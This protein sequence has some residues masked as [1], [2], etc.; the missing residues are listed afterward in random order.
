MRG[1]R[2][3]I[4]ALAIASAIAGL[5]YLVQ[6]HDSSPEHSSN[7][8]AANGASAVRLFAEAMGHPT[9]QVEGSFDMPANESLLFVFTPTS[10]YTSDDA[11]EVAA[12]VRNGGVLVYASEEGDPELD[13]ALSVSRANGIVTSDV[14]TALPILDSVSKAAGGDT[15]VPLLPSAS[16]VAV[17][18][19][20]DGYALGYIEHLGFGEVVVLADP[21]VICNGYLEQRDNGRLLSDLLGLVPGGAAVSFDEYHHGLILS[22]FAPQAWLLTPWGSALLW[23]I[24]A[25]FFGL[26]LRGRSFGPL[27]RREPEVARADAEWAVA[28]GEL[29]R[30]S[31]GRAMTLGVLASAT[32][33]AV[34]AQTGLPAQPRERFWSALHQR[35]PELADELARAEQSLYNASGGDAE[36]LS[37]AQVLHRI[38]F[39]PRPARNHATKESR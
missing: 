34:A 5:A 4:V 2:G 23:M 21:L 14:E 37:A 20:P 26:L 18:R 1:L 19:S 9:N 24:L 12:W 25:V 33:R 17:L 28:V 16:Q 7:S 35:A 6:P 15:A 29:L 32:E 13:Q 22:D 8:D 27:M 10:P 31:G 11:G 36:L 3:W 39:P 30:R 38:A